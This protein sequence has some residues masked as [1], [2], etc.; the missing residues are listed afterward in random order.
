MIVGVENEPP[1]SERGM[2]IYLFYP[3]CVRHCDSVRQPFPLH[4]TKGL[5]TFLILKMSSQ[6]NRGYIHTEDA[7][8][9]AKAKGSHTCREILMTQTASS[10]GGGFFNVRTL[11]ADGAPPWAFRGLCEDHFKLI[12]ADADRSLRTP[13]GRLFEG[14]A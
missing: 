3:L 12:V 4:P 13:E 6:V 2:R 14:P 5:R 10:A 9:P 7:F 8:R 1:L 11:K